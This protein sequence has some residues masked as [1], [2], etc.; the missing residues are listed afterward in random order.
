[1]FCAWVQKGEY[2][3]VS[4]GG[5]LSVLTSNLSLQSCFGCNLILVTIASLSTQLSR[6]IN[7]LADVP[8]SVGVLSPQAAMCGHS[9]A[10]EAIAKAIFS[11][12]SRHY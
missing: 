7:S 9:I 5:R 8:L 6:C 4:K 3:Y 10:I 12:G 2:M 11:S 1:M